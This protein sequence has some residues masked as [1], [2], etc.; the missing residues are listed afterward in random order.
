M[1]LPAEIVQLGVAGVVAAV[2]W[3]ILKLVVD[4]KLHTDSEIEV[5]D[6]RVSEL[7]SQVNTLTSALNA[8]NEQS[9]TIITLWK[10]LQ[11]EDDDG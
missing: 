4:G 1:A 10:A 11:A 5:R 2:L 7:L 6:Q 8:A 3:Y 9:R